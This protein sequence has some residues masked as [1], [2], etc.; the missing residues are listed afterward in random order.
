[1]YALKTAPA[2][3]ENLQI[4]V[5]YNKSRMVIEFE[6]KEIFTSSGILSSEK[7]NCVLVDLHGFMYTCTVPF[8]RSRKTAGNNVSHTR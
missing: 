5:Y 6:K 1:M 3:V 8:L 4:V 2:I 7:V